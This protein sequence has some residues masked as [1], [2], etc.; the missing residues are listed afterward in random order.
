METRVLIVDDRGETLAALR[1]LGER[2]GED[3]L[4]Q[5]AAS[6]LSQG[7]EWLAAMRG[8][9]AVGH[10]GALASAA[11]SLCGAAAVLRVRDLE[12]CSLQLQALARQGELVAARALLPAVVASYERAAAELLGSARQ[13][14]L[15]GGPAVAQG[16]EGRF[17]PVGRAEL[18]EDVS[19]VG[20]HGR[21]R[22]LETVGDLLVRESLGHQ[23]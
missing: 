21:L 3:L 15:Q 4:G 1:R 10:C 12:R 9:L 18:A 17:D 11:H 8:A 7:R 16:E 14:L 19:E 22:D 20:A 23:P 5:V 2:L 6:F 13:A